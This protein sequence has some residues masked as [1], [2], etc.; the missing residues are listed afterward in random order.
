MTGFDEL[1]GNEPT[2]SDRE[3]LR[4]VHEL[5]LV[6]GPPPELDPKLEAGPTLGMTLTR[7]RRR[8]R[9]RIG[10]LV[11]AIAV[12]ALVALIIGIS[13]G[14]HTPR[15]VSIPMRGTSFAPRAS[16]TLDVLPAKA[17]KQP[18]KLIVRGLPRSGRTAYVVYLV[19]DGHPVAPC[20]R[21]IV[22]D[23]ARAQTVHLNSPYRLE[24]ADSWVV[25]QEGVGAHGVTVLQPSTA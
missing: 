15:L 20:G 14:G 10:R 6:A 2:G 1:I 19:R 16:G 11:P 17:G 4:D 5:L 9:P 7:A 8:S 24:S 18:M 23:P 21:F 3:R 13:T 12:A 25:L 22:T